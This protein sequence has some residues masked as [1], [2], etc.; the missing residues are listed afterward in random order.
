MAAMV[1]VAAVHEQ[2]H[3]RAGED[4][5]K[6]QVGPDVFTVFHQQKIGD[7]ADQAER[8]KAFWREPERR[9]TS[10]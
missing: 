9:M 10:H 7:G 5:Q 4:D 3:E 2:V 8:R 6:R 1:S